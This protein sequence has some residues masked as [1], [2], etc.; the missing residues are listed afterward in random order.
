MKS[1]A[2][3]FGIAIPIAIGVTF[4]T[5]ILMILVGMAWHEFDILSPKGF[6]SMI[7]FGI[8]FTVIVGAFTS[9]K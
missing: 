4:W 2:T 6:Y 1:I 8:I 3:I 7:P 9:N 5:W